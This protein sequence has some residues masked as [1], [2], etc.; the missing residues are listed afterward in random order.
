SEHPDIYRGIE[1]GI[2]S[3]FLKILDMKKVK[4]LIVSV[5]L[6]LGS[7]TKDLVSIDYGEIN[8]AIFPKTEADIEAMV[9]SVYYPLRGSW[10]DGIFSTS[11]R[12]VMMI[13]D[14]TTEI[15][16]GWYDEKER[17]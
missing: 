3:A 4:L 6:S 15:L 2:L 8:P 14:C 5:V 7:C 9:N 17:A 11:E 13:S 1:F 10:W 12:G 16:T